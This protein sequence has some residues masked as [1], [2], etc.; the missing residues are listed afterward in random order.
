[1]VCD[2]IDS[3]GCWNWESPSFTP[4]PPQS[5]I[6][7]IQAIPINLTSTL[8][9]TT[10]WALSRDG[11]FNLASAY[12]L[13]KGLN[14]LNLPTFTSNWIWKMNVPQ[15]IIIFLWLCSHNSVPVREV[16]G[17]RGFT[18]DQACPLYHSQ[19]E[20]INHLLK[21]C[22]FV[23]SFW[24]QIGLPSKVIQ[25][26]SLPLL[27]W[28]HFSG[29]FNIISKR[30]H[31]P[32]KVIFCFGIWSL[33]LN[34]NSIVHQR[35]Q[36]A[37]PVIKDCIAKAAKFYFLTQGTNSSSH[38]RSLP[39]SWTKPNPRWHK[40]NMDASVLSSSSFASGG[41]LLRDS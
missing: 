15:K 39:V 7:I 37:A 1:M 12:L 35:K 2:F 17:S 18:L 20:S 41:G 33:W 26:F 32:R 8:D 11:N 9:D 29:T 14:A 38:K 34:R 25:F 30:H 36:A 27:D 13:A 5:F 22:P 4:P 31:I 21:D 19:V 23:V 16:L 28:L 3:N 40:L 6:D 24:N 10:A